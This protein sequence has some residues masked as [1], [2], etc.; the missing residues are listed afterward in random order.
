[1]IVDYDNVALILGILLA[2]GGVAG[3]I[4]AMSIARN[5][6]KNT[7]LNSLQQT[8]DTIQCAYQETIADLEKRINY[9]EVENVKQY[10]QNKQ[11][12]KRIEQLEKDLLIAQNKITVLE[13]ELATRDIE[14]QKR[15]VEIMR[16]EQ[17]NIELRRSNGERTGL[18]TNDNT[19]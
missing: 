2:G 15:D 11:Y 16:L 5:A 19:N 18:Q 14:I 17:Q 10:E 4:K 9:L 8:I 12:Q 1:M 13:R 6:N 7:D 3:L